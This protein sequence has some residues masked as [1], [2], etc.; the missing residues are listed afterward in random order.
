MDCFV[1]QPASGRPKGPDPLAPR[2]D[3]RKHSI[4]ISLTVFSVK[5]M[6]IVI[7]FVTIYLR[8]CYGSS[9]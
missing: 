6:S 2:N 3:N 1:A 4:F 5:L 8:L 9:S 7:G